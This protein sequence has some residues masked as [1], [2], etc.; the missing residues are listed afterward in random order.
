[1]FL[2]NGPSGI[3][4]SYML[5]GATPYYTGAAPLSNQFLMSRLQEE[6]TSSQKPKSLYESDLEFLAQV[7]FNFK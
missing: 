2:G 6:I 5:S 1:M 7:Q 3:S 4:L